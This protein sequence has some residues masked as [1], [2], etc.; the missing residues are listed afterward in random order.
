LSEIANL[1]AATGSMNSK[2]PVKR[3][4]FKDYTDED[5]SIDWDACRVAE[6]ANG[7]R[8]SSCG[9]FILMPSGH[10]TT[11]SACTSL[12]HDKEHVYHEA[13]VRCPKCGEVWNPWETED[14]QLM[15]EGE[16]NVQCDQCDHEFEVSTSVT[17]S[18]QSPERTPEP[19]KLV[20]YY[21]CKPCGVSWN[22]GG[23]N[24]EDSEDFL[25][26]HECNKPGELVMQKENAD[27]S[28]V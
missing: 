21:R 5:G 17:Y 19:P 12:T 3:V 16:H 1:L 13:R 25:I 23:G 24:G 7:Q 8:C 9:T 15:Q 28:D 27:V 18:F 2:E 6:V 4:N 11:C 26:C 22:D 14:F 10:S 20:K